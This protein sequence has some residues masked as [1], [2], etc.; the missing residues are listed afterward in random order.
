MPRALLKLHS[1]RTNGLFA[2]ENVMKKNGFGYIETLV[3]LAIMAIFLKIALVDYTAHLRET[4]RTMAQFQLMDLREQIINEQRASQ[5][6]LPV[7]IQGIVDKAS[8][9]YYTITSYSTFLATNNNN[10]DKSLLDYAIVATPV[11]SKSQYNDGV[12]CITLQGYKY[13]QE[14]A[15][16]CRFALYGKNDPKRNSFKTI[17]EARSS[18]WYGD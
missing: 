9:P 11:A 7:V 12:I 8:N 5:K 15:P 3:V 10:T 6:P 4:R 18:T 2:S 14:K 17:S 1:I 16:N 13:W